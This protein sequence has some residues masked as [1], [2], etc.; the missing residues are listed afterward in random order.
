MYSNNMSTEIH[1]NLILIF[2]N[3]RSDPLISLFK[4]SQWSLLQPLPQAITE[5]R[6]SSFYFMISCPV[7]YFQALFSIIPLYLTIRIFHIEQV[8]W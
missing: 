8:A 3:Y 4:S 1:I 2:L 7:S 5:R 6:K